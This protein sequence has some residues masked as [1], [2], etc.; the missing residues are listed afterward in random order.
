MKRDGW[1]E[2]YQSYQERDVFADCDVL[3]SFFAGAGSHSVLEGVYVVNGVEGPI[4][5]VPLKT[6]RI[7]SMQVVQNIFIA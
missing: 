4:Q 2:Y 1:F 3:V 7:R 6:I 5:I